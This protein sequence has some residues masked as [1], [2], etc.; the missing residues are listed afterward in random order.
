MAGISAVLTIGFNP[1]VRGGSEFLQMNG[2][3]RSMH[4]AE[5]RDPHARWLVLNDGILGN[6]P[7]MLGIHGLN[8]VHFY[9][10]FAFWAA[11][12]PERRQVST[13]NRYASVNV[14]LTRGPT[15]IRSVQSDGVEVFLD[16][17]SPE[18]ERLN[19][20]YVLLRGGPSDLK[21]V[22]VD[23]SVEYDGAGLRL[24]RLADGVPR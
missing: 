1:L 3:A 5:A 9:P 8:G 14:F 11:L 16:P 22:F 17:R 23:A 24:L 12:D 10:Q 20:Q 2:L 6:Y 15:Q 21:D 13:Y 7:R 4:R 19:V 18:F